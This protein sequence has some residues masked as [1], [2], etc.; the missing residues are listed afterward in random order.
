MVTADGGKLRGR[1]REQRRIAVPGC[2]VTAVTLALAPAA[3]ADLI[4][5][6]D[7][8]CDPR[9]WHIG[10]WQGGKAGP[11]RHRGDGIG[12][13]LLRGRVTSPHP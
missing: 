3:T 7:M 4:Q 12:E 10:S 5:V 9:G 11:A 8:V 1:L 2:N 13:G 6:E